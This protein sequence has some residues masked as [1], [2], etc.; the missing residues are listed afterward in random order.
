MRGVARAF[1]ISAVVYGLLG[2]LLGL[3]M[4]MRHDHGQLPT[5]AHIMVVGWV[6]FAI[7]GFFYFLLGAAV[8]RWL[9]LAHLWLAQISVA[10]MVAGLW[11]YYGGQTQFEPL[12][13]IGAMGYGASFVIFAAA[14]FMVMRERAAG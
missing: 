8:P 4:A 2:V 13:A 11:L 12:A 14:A 9:A 5:H 10:V 7:F 6:S 3:D 1:F